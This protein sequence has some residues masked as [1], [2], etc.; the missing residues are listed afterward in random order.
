MPDAEREVGQMRYA[1]VDAF[2][3]L[4]VA[5]LVVALF[6]LW[7]GGVAGVSVALWR[8]RAYIGA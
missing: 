8:L 3:P 4:L 5:L 2:A 7:V 1:A 6:G